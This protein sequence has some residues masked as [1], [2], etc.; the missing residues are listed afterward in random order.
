M[1]QE[2]Q[3]QGQ[4]PSSQ[5]DQMSQ[6][7]KIATNPQAM[8]ALAAVQPQMADQIGKMYANQLQREKFQFEKEKEER[9]RGVITPE[10]KTRLSD[11]FK[12]QD[13]LLKSGNVG[14]RKTISAQFSEQG[15]QDRAEFDTLSASI[16]AALMP[17]VSKGTLAKDRFKYIMSLLPKAT[18]T[19]GGI[20]GKIKALKRELQVIDQESP[21]SSENSTE[22]TE[23]KELQIGQTATNPKTGVKIEWTGS[24]WRKAK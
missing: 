22:N 11:V 2:M 18:D 14:M 4:M 20:K 5:N 1:T 9:K 6:L 15:R 16:E 8:T 13:E 23:K 12:R 24:N 7:E 19:I 10:T 3:S 17:L 21:Q